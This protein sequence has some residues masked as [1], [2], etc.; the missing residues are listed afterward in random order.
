M[1]GMN[2]TS[3]RTAAEHRRE[4]TAHLA[5]AKGCRAELD[6]LYSAAGHRDDRERIAQLHDSLR[7]HLQVAKVEAA[8]AGSAPQ[9]V[10]T[11]WPRPDG[12]PVVTT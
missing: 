5:A 3:V 11:G 6:A 7:F 12:A 9:G 4:A 1:Q 8:L 10:P 2:D